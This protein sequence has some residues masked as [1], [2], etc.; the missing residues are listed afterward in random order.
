MT[1]SLAQSGYVR[2]K[3]GAYRLVEKADRTRFTDRRL[4]RLVNGVVR[5]IGK[6]D[7]Y[8][9]VSFF[10]DDPN[11]FPSSTRDAIEDR[12]GVAFAVPLDG[13]GLYGVYLRRDG[14]AKLS[15]AD[16][17]FIIA[18]EIAHCILNHSSPE[19]GADGIEEEANYFAVMLWGFKPDF[20]IVGVTTV[21]LL[22]VTES[23][24][25]GF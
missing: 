9:C 25:M 8:K 14:L 2:G 23:D 3:D 20:V 22:P 4:E 15:D 12:R 19:R 7:V 5:S 13:A 16:V 17:R 21:T 24:A 1:T 11:I 6:N 18:H 10:S